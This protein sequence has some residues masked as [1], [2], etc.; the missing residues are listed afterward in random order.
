MSHTQNTMLCKGCG[1]SA[2]EY[3]EKCN[4]IKFI[5]TPCVDC[6]CLTPRKRCPECHQQRFE[7]TCITCQQPSIREYCGTCYWNQKPKTQK[8]K[9]PHC[10][11]QVVGET[12]LHHT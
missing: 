7:N 4:D 5:W 3:C 6:Q 9:Q 2:S 8:C 11:V 10:Y 1:V 12:C